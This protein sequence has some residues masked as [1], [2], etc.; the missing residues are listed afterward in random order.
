M[1]AFPTMSRLAIPF[2]CLALLLAAAP[3]L[4]P[5]AAA[6]E[7]V[8]MIQNRD[9]PALGTLAPIERD[10][11][12]HVRVGKRDDI[13]WFAV[14]GVDGVVDYPGLVRILKARAGTRRPSPHGVWL[15]ATAD[16]AWAHVLVL[17][18]ACAEAGIYR[19][20]V[21]ARSEA[22]GRALGFPL[23]IP[24]DPAGRP[25]AKAG[26]LNVRVDALL[27]EEVKGPSDIGHIYAA[28][29]RANERRGEFGVDKVVAKV[30][31]SPN[32]PLQYALSAIDLLYRGGCAGVQVQMSMRTSWRGLDVV[33]VVEIQGGV[34]SRTPQALKPPVLQPRDRPWGIDGANEPG[35]VDFQVADLPLIDAAK[36]GGTREKPRPRPNYAA[37]PGGV[38]PAEAKRVDEAIRRWALELGVDMNQMIRDPRGISPTVQ[39]RF[40][41]AMRRPQVLP[42]VVLPVRKAFPDATGAFVSTLRLQA[43]LFHRGKI[44][45]TADVTLGLTGPQAGLAFGAW[46]PRDPN[47]NVTLAPFDVD[48]YAA[49]DAAA[50]RVWLE[51]LFLHFRAPPVGWTPPLYPAA[52]LL[53]YLPDAA[54]ASTR[55][56]LETRRAGVQALQQAVRATPFDRVVLVART[57]TAAVT[58]AD[59]KVVGTLTMRFEPQ[60]GELRINGLTPRRAP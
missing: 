2:A 35:W 26:R 21:R 36:D 33:P 5:S 1:L 12:T 59:R 48:P 19:V 31:I 11:V 23:F 32:A 57:G 17:V 10:N 18:K 47:D 4:A 27:K 60:E 37:T 6:D 16:H 28:A 24:A 54:L 38:P 39:Q 45:G 3:F 49:G 22:T 7:R 44:Q 20:G 25:G 46:A 30:W 34:A 41:V 58:G 43:H 50:F 51:D 8:P 29:R 53:R 14:L 55:Q 9:L 42:Q 40:S 52:E 15:T 56:A 13:R